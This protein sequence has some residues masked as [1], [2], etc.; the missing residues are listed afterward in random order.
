[1]LWR[2]FALVFVLLAS[3]VFIVAI[4]GAIDGALR[5]GWL[6]PSGALASLAWYL[7]LKAV[8]S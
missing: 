4:F 6:I 5:V 7:F 8:Q 3:F 1:M 2:I